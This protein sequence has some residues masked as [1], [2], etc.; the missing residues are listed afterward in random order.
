MAAGH[1]A[2]TTYA[3][4]PLSASRI[5]S[6]GSLSR[7]V[8]QKI[9]KTGDVADPAYPHNLI[10]LIETDRPD[11]YDVDKPDNFIDKETSTALKL[12]SWKREAGLKAIDSV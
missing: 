6:L 12:E 3:L 4:I 11:K 2:S 10:K 7:S 1:D 8:F 9:W 5:V